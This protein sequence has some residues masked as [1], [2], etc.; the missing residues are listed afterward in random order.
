MERRLAAIMLTDMVGYSRLMGLDEEGTIARQK[1]HREEIIDRNISA[2]GG[3]I[4]KTTG[5]GLLVE[6]PSVVDAVKCAVDVQRELAERDA[7]TP[8]DRRVQYRIGINLGDIVID[9]DDILGDGVNVAARL[10]GLSEPGG[11]CIAGNVFDQVRNKLDVAFR[12]LGDQELKNIPNPVRAYQVVLDE[13]DLDQA[14]RNSATPLPVE[15]KSSIAV[16]PFANMSGDPEQDYF[17]D[18]ITEDIITALSNVRTF[19]VLARNSTFVYKGKSVDARQIGRDLNVN[20]MIEGSVRRAGDRV[21]VTAQLIETATGDHLWAERYD[22]TLD[23][24]FDLQDRITSKIVGTVEPE[25]VRA[26]GLRLRGKPP[27]N[28][29]AYDW[30]LRGQAYMHNVTPEDTRRALECFEKA[31]ELDPNYGR[32]YAFATWCHRREV[33]ERGSQALSKDDQ[34]KVMGLARNALRCDRNDPFVL[35]YVAATFAFIGKDF[36]EALALN[37]RALS[38]HPNSI[39]FLAGKA[40]YSC[41]KGDTVQAIQAGERAIAINPNEPAIWV[42][43]WSIAEAYLQE[44]RFEE[45][46]EFARQAIRHNENLGSG[47][48]ILAAALA[49]LGNEGEA[50]KALAA[51]LNINSGMTITTFQE[52]YHVARFKNLDAYLDGLRKAGLPE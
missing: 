22:G 8:E 28:M 20:Y 32:A 47:Y 17:A 42:I 44:L 43:Y 13:K 12:D 48:F 5:D 2:H 7:D 3:R 34:R 25:L 29:A 4:V 18:G 19:M 40:R 16:L 30:L 45:A 33:M 36:D 23:D 10:E 50:K 37:D 6:F 49:H 9:G 21:R 46:V 24:I 31:I 11:I 39:R 51:A 52:N 27:E 38:M 14:D 35:G 1:A 15:N 41:F 26:E